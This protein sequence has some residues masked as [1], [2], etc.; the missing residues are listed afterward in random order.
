MNVGIITARRG[1]GKHLWKVNGRPLIEYPIRA[2]ID[3]ATLNA[4]YVSTDCPDIADI[5]RM[6]GCEV[7]DRPAELARDDSNHGDA[8]KHAVEHVERQHPALTNVAILLGNT[9]MVDGSLVDQCMDALATDVEADSIMTVWLAADDHPY[10]AMVCVDGE[11]QP[12]Q[13]VRAE[14]NRQSYPHVHYYDQGVWA[15]RK[16]TVRERRGP[17]PWWWMGKRCKPLVREW[18]TGRDVHDAFELA[19]S[20]WW[21]T[22]NREATHA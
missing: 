20:E 18:V 2:A 11:L 22:R 14:T 6:M 7:I 5:A 4:V 16:H 8:I 12:Y 9:V 15:M 10:R 1:K 3:A 13:D 19:L 21:V 17:G